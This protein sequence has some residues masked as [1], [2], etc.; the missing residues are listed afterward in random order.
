[1]NTENE[2]QFVCVFNSGGV[3]GVSIDEFMSYI[4]EFDA[5][6]VVY[7]WTKAIPFTIVQ[8]RLHQ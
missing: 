4:N 6:A 1:M 5:D 2:F 3:C 7:A 8:F